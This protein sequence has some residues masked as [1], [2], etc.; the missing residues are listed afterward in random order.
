[1]YK[2]GLAKIDMT[3]FE[4]NIG[5]FGFGLYEHR[6]QG[7]ETPLYAR[8]L[9]IEDDSKNKTAIVVCEIASI[10]NSLKQ[11]VL[12]RLKQK[13]IFDFTNENLLLSASH[14]HS[15]AGGYFHYPFYNFS[16]GGF[17]QPVLDTYAESI[18]NAIVKA[19]SVLV[20][21]T[22]TLH[23]GTFDNEKKVCFNRSLRAYNTNKDVSKVALGQ[24]HLATDREM[25]L[26]KVEDKNKKTLGCINWFGVHTTSCGNDHYK[27]CSDNKGYAASFHEEKYTSIN[28]DFVSIFAQ[29]PCGDI[30]PLTQNLWIP[31]RAKKLKESDY[32][33][34]AQNGKLQSEKADELLTSKAEIILNGP[35]DCILTHSDLSKVSIVDNVSN[36]K[37]QIT[38]D[39]ALGLA[40]FRGTVD[41][42]GISS[43]LNGFLSLLTPIVSF[44]EHAKLRLTKNEKEK[45]RLVLKYQLHTTKKILIETTR[46]RILGIGSLR[47]IPAFTDKLIEQLVRHDKAGALD[48]YPLT[49]SILPL[50]IVNIGQLALIALPAEITTIAGKRIK[51]TLQDIL[52]EK[53]IDQVIIAPYCN[54]YSGY[55]TTPEEHQAQC[56][57]GGH[58]LFGKKTLTAYISEMSMLSHELLK[59]KNNRTIS[60]LQPLEFPEEVLNKRLY[61]AN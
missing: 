6:A 33:H 13:A 38:T 31:N 4:P 45:Q 11:E 1:M 56:Y 46:K 27:I 37:K 14:T 24:E 3:Y 47:I 9:V 32:I 17:H 7:I 51:K 41:G 5:L 36:V 29:K 39:G 57:E 2:A 10:A 59:E 50:Q 15:A 19:N 12:K 26:L 35:I 60:S 16:N 44:F 18:A 23:R 61:V 22:L 34:A 52:K 48:N 40:F 30:T 42:I 58:T 25:V 21:A 55:I 54:E 20:D 28:P 43:L 53:A 8:A 49:P